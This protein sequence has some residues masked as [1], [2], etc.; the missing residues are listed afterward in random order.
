MKPLTMQE[1]AA[2]SVNIPG[3]VEQLAWSLYD[4]QTYV[5]A[6]QTALTFF[7][8][9][10][11]SSGSGYETTNLDAAGSVPKGQ[12]FL[13]QCIELDILPA[14]DVAD[15][16]ALSAYAND[17]YNFFRKGYLEFKIGSKLYAQHGPLGLYPPRTGLSGFA[18]TATTQTTTDS[19]AIYAVNRGR[20]Y[21]LI[22]LTIPSNQN[23][24]VTLKWDSAQAISADATVKT[25]LSGILFRNAQ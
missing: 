1:M 10:V 24:S 9:P 11:G 21:A 15:A 8:N 23:F 20:P 5:A 4:S 17:V 3:K 14:I 13:V 16:A 25:R 6:G 22:P 7:Q 2:Y 12:I 18:A 19:A